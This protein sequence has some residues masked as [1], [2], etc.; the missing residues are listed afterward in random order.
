MIIGIFLNRRYFLLH[1][2]R[3]DDN[4]KVKRSNGLIINAFD[5]YMIDVQT[6][7]V[8]FSALLTSTSDRQFSH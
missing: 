1:L 5:F 3:K 6:Y 8:T 4:S 2:W 7:T